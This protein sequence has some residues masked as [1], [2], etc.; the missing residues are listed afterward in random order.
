MLNLPEGDARERFT[1]STI[2]LL[3][4]EL[5]AAPWCDIP[6]GNPEGLAALN[7]A[8]SLRG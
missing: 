6:A 4:V 1:Y 5:F 8:A 3:R 2:A 7:A